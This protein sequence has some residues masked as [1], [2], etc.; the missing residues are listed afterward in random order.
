MTGLG[1]GGP[2]D[3]IPMPPDLSLSYEDIADGEVIG[4]GGNADVYRVTVERSGREIPVAVKQPR[5]QGT[6]DAATAERFVAE[7]DV[8]RNL[9]NHDHIVGLLDWGSEPLPWLAMEY[10]DGGT[11]EATLSEERLPL[12]QAVWV[13]LCLCR[14]LRHAHRHGV[15]HH[16]IKPANV[17]FRETPNSW[18]VPKISD[19]GLARL[20]LTETGSVEGLSPHYAAPE[21]FDADQYGSPDDRTDIYQVGTLV[22]E[23]VTGDPPFSG[24]ATAVM[25]SVLSEKPERPSARADVPAQLDDILGPALEKDP[26]ERYDSVVPLRD[27]LEELFA[28]VR[29]TRAARTS[30]TEAERETEDD[31]RQTGGDGTP[32]TRQSDSA[33]VDSRPST[34]ESQQSDQYS[35]RQNRPPRRT[36]TGESRQSNA[37][38]GES[39]RTGGR[40]ETNESKQ[41]PQHQES[42]GRSMS[43]FEALSRRQA[44][45]VILVMVVTA[46]AL[47]VFVGGDGGGGNGIDAGT[48]N[49]IVNGGENGGG[50]GGGNGGPAPAAFELDP[51]T[52]SVTNSDTINISTTVRNT[53]RETD[54][55]TAELS[56]NGDVVDSDTKNIAGGDSKRFNFNNINVDNANEYT[57]SAGGSSIDGLLT[58]Q[59]QGEFTLSGAQDV[60]VREGESAPI[61]VDVENVGDTMGS[62][63]LRLSME[64]SSGS[65]VYQDTRPKRLNAG[66]TQSVSFTIATSDLGPGE[67]TYTV[68]SANDEASGQLTVQEP[69]N[70]EVSI[71]SENLEVTAG[72]ELEV[73]VTVENTGGQQ[74]TQTVEL[75]AQPL[76]TDSTQVQLAGGD[77]TTETLS[78]G[79]SNDDDGSYTVTVSTEDGDTDEQEVTVDSVTESDPAKFE[80]TIDSTNLEVTEGE[81]LTVEFTVE[82]TGGQQGTQ[83]VRLEVPGLESAT[84]SIL[85]NLGDGT[86]TEETLTIETSDGDAEDSPYTATVSPEDG[87]PASTDVR[88]NPA[89]ESEPANFTVDIVGTNA[90]VV[91]G[92]TLS[93]NATIE[94]T[95]DESAIQTVTADAGALG[96]QTTPA[97]LEGGASTTE[98]LSVG[99]SSGD[100][101]EY[102]VTVSTHDDSNTQ[103]VRV[104]PTQSLEFNS[105]TLDFGDTVSVEIESPEDASLSVVV[106]YPNANQEIVAGYDDGV[107]PGSNSVRLTK[108]DGIPGKHTAYLIPEDNVSP[109]IGDPLPDEL[110]SK[111]IANA[112]ATI[113][114]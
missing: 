31:Q 98:T 69:S 67:Y 36:S 55:I 42:E 4:Q 92:G 107:S 37:S 63:L 110:Q 95:G 65:E 54:S 41:S 84:S 97:V 21:Q 101:G 10:M 17:L 96:N 106:T 38:T 76:G 45:V 57:I 44:L 68:S 88:V 89:T 27:A 16:G 47:F 43:V 83:T 1:T 32:S 46:G 13:G 3:A 111:S 74:G 9:A 66:S 61:S 59:P 11:L 85:V 56:I 34:E 73:P 75:D 70:F 22:Y 2:P 102:T 78:V 26:T 33:G 81:D 53:G 5:L 82:N 35:Y 58:T 91:E 86:S 72:E 94:N 30:S 105:Q 71:D 62:Q 79:T 20:M 52:R 64:D 90:P 50:N 113:S 80:V 77:S 60:P 100:A 51:P 104:N 49:T 39:A 48:E 8:W 103:T 109:R 93:V 29:E 25:Q 19:W 87:T 40:T 23:L 6:L 15:A 112:T 24:S 18:M 99:T 7:A 14:V 28:S 108:T 12:E 114:E